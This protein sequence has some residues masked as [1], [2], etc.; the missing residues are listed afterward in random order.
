VLVA[1]GVRGASVS[2]AGGLGVSDGGASAGVAVAGAGVNCAVG[3]GVWPG[4]RVVPGVVVTGMVGSGVGGTN[5]VGVGSSVSV[6]GGGGPAVGVAVLVG[7]NDGVADGSV[8]ARVAV[9]ARRWRVGVGV[10]PC[11]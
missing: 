8:R 2:V 11:R 7:V 4:R 10:T 5:C 9:A 6:G 3:A 1:A